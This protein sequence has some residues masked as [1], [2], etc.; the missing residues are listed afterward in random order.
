MITLLKSFIVGIC[1][2][3]P[4][5]SGSVI[6]VSLG[7]YEKF[8]EIIT[9]IRKVN[10]NKTFIILVIIG[11]FSG[12]FLTSNLLV[13]IFRYKNI[14]YYILIGIILSEI[15]SLIKKVHDYSGNKIKI[16][17]LLLVFVFSLTLDSLN[18]SNTITSYSVFKYFLGG[19]LFSFG[20]VFPGVSS[21]FF[22]L[23]LGIYEDII[24][25]VTKPF[26]LFK[27]FY[28]YLPFIIGTLFGL[29]IFLRLLSYLLENK[30]ETI[31]SIIIGFMISS[32][33]VL[34]PKFTFDIK[35]YIGIT[36]MIV[37]FIIFIR[38][39]IKNNK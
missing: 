17:P 26:L 5:V 2:I 21:S 37:S 36:L 9:N 18:K 28:F 38:I 34:L 12:I 4:G 22:L 19:I 13:Y 32:V 29:L 27:N 25:L 30:Y 39:K 8:I 31:Y 15:P 3:M 16:L 1:A 6:A 35:N 20:K 10:E 24:V 23:S 11:L 33:L 14:L 7:I